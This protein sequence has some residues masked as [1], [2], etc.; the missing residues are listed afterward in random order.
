MQGIS[1]WQF[2]QPSRGIFLRHNDRITQ[3]GHGDRQR[4][5]VV[6]GVEG[7]FGWRVGAGKGNAARRCARVTVPVCVR[8]WLYVTVAVRDRACARVPEQ[9][10]CPF[11]P[12]TPARVLS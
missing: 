9:Q 11:C 1:S 5:G 4:G 3:K 6:G 8:P 12:P 2:G 10:P 7:D